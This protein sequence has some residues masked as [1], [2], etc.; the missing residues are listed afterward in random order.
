MEQS[1]LSEMSDPGLW[2]SWAE[3]VRAWAE[4]SLFTTATLIELSIILVAAL[5]AWPIALRLEQQFEF[6]LNRPSRY[7]VMDRLWN[8]LRDIDFPGVWLFLQ[9]ISV[10]ITSGMGVRNTTLVVTTSLLTAWVIVRMATI[11]V[12]NPF[13]SRTIATTAWI[14]AALNIVGLLD[15]T[16][17]VLSDAS[18]TLGQVTVSALTIIQGLIALGILLWVTTVLGQLIEGRLKS[19]S[20]LSPS[21]QVLSAKLIRIVLGA[22][23]FLSALAIVGVDLTAL[24]VFGGAIG[25]GLGFGL[26][27]IFANLVSG[28]ILLLDKSIKPGDVIAVQNYYGRVDSLGARYVS[29][30]TR[31]GIEHLIPNEELIVNRV[32]NWSHSQNLLRLRKKIGVHY[33]ADIH[34]A[35]ELCLEAAAETTRILK[36]PK[37]VCLLSDFGDSSVVLEMRFWIDD[38][39]NGRA[40]VTSELLTRIWDKFHANGIEIPY[41]QMDLH[42]RSSSLKTPAGGLYA[43]DSEVE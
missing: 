35:R 34:K 24:A 19:S 17:L 37:A 12:P 18:I 29:V 16:M 20:S 40:N 7:P 28:F 21:I 11:V 13:W 10:L 43:D 15:R 25:V 23:A 22:F 27:K 14:I 3:Q 9:W 32:E 30:T 42:L 5:I 4:S 33:K 38:P 1:L 26:Q 36:D 2:A 6:I 31:D 41:P 39:M 8:T